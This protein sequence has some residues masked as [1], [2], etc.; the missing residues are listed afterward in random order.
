MD[1]RKTCGPAVYKR[2][3]SILQEDHRARLIE[4]GKD[5]ALLAGM[6][7]THRACPECFV[8]INKDGGCDQISCPCG[9]SFDF[10][11]NRGQLRTVI[12]AIMQLDPSTAD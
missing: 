3:E 10:G 8:L 12:K 11:S 1:V 4:I 5:P 6:A 7:S 2:F 9:E